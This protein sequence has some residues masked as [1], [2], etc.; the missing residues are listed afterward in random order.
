M[1][2]FDGTG[3]ESKGPMTGRGQGYCAVEHTDTGAVRGVVGVQ[4]RPFFGRWFG[5]LGRRFGMGR[6]RRGRQGRGRW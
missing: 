1:P 3:P 4:N 2:R 6:P 5:F